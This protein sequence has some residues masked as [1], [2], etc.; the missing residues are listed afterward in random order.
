MSCYFT[1]NNRPPMCR[2]LVDEREKLIFALDAMQTW[3]AERARH[4]DY[5][6]TR[7][8]GKGIDCNCLLEHLHRLLCETRSMI[9]S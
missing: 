7:E 2:R 6:P 1:E 3:L 4:A 9:A 5:C 8:T